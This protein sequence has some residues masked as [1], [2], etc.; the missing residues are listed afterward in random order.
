M[1][2]FDNHL[3]DCNVEKGW[4]IPTRDIVRLSFSLFSVS[5]VE[6]PISDVRWSALFYSTPW[7]YSVG[8]GKKSTRPLKFD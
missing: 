2:E 7:K 5:V 3:I 4:C 8:C 1:P 6:N